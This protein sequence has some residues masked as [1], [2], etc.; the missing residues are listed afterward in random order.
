VRV[1]VSAASSRLD[2]R[3][4]PSSASAVV[5][6]AAAAAAAATATAAAAVSAASIAATAAAAAATGVVVAAILRDW[7]E[8][9]VL[10]TSAR[11]TADLVV[12]DLL[13]VV[14]E[15]R[16]AASSIGA[17]AD[18]EDFGAGS[19]FCDDTVPRHDLFWLRR[20]SEMGL[21]SVE[22]SI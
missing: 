7:E 10:R 12:R 2:L 9:F 15:V 5:A 3:G 6:D 22:F 11:G 14:A 21:K 13:G 19:A 4:R 16:E 20:R 1:V 17:E 18:E 8:T